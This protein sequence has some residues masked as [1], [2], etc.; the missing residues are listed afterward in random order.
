MAAFATACFLMLAIAA[1]KKTTA[2]ASNAANQTSP[3]FSDEELKQQ[4]LAWNLKT[5]VEPYENAGFANPEWDAPAKLALTEFARARA[6]VPDENE[7]SAQIISKNASVAVQSGCKD[8]MVAY[9]YIKFA[10]DQ[11]NS[12]EAFTEAFIA[13][14][15]A[16]NNSSYPPIRK[17]YAAA[18]TMDQIFFTYGTNSSS[19]PATAEIGG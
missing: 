18:R 15:K 8:P 12:K 7:P 4:R 6:N 5:L 13:M 2:P 9:L 3:V 16:M 19:Q 14:A 17:F 11:T 10:M 1:C